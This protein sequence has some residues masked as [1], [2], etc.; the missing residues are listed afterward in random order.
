MI[1]VL[2]FSSLF[3]PLLYLGVIQMS[4]K[5]TLFIIFFV[6]TLQSIFNATD[7]TFVI[8]RNRAHPYRVSDN[9]SLD[10]F[11][12]KVCDICQVIVKNVQEREGD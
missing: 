9:G 5:K 3:M 6:E 11:T 8:K 10:D 4:T 12:P 7:Q 1:A 2:F